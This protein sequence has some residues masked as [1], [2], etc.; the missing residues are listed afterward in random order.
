[1]RKKASG[2]L[3]FLLVLMIFL[4]SA[5]FLKIISFSPQGQL[6][7]IINPEIT[8]VFSKDMKNLGKKS[9]VENFVKISPSIEGKFFWRGSST[10]VFRAFK[11]FRYSTL[12]KVKIKKWIKSLKGNFLDRNYV[13][14]F[15]TPLARPVAVKQ[16]SL[17][18]DK[19]YG[20]EIKYFSNK[21]EYRVSKRIKVKEPL[22]IFF[23]QKINRRKNLEKIEIFNEKTLE[24][25]NVSLKFYSPDT[26]LIKFLSP[27]KEDNK[28]FIKLSKGFLS[29]E[30]PLPQ[31]RDIFVFFKTEKR[32]KY[33]GDKKIFIFKDKPIFNLS[34][35]KPIKKGSVCKARNYLKVFFIEDGVRKE[36]QD[37]SVSCYYN[38]LRIKLKN[39]GADSYLV[40]ISKD[41]KS[42]SGENLGENQFIR[43]KIC[44][45]TPDLF[46][47]GFSNNKL[48]LKIKG[49]L[50]LKF[51]ILKIKDSKL[52]AKK[53][54][55]EERGNVS[56]TRYAEFISNS[57]GD[58]EEF[59]IDFN[60][61][62]KSK[63]GIF[64]VKINR[65]KLSNDCNVL[66]FY[67]NRILGWKYIVNP[68]TLASSI[69]IL[70]GGTFI[71][72]FNRK[73]ITGES[74]VL[75]EFYKNSELSFK[76]KTDKDGVFYGDKRLD[77]SRWYFGNQGV[78]LLGKR[79][80]Y[81]F[82]YTGK[83]WVS[84]GGF[85]DETGVK[86]LI[87]TDRDFYLPGDSVYIGGI[88]KKRWKN[89]LAR[90]KDK[91]ITIII[92]DPTYK[93]IKRIE[94]KTDRFG[95]FFNEVKTWGGW[96][97]GKYFI[98]VK[99]KGAESREKIVKIDFYKLNKIELEE[100]FENEV[101][102]ASQ[103]NK[104][105]V[106][107]KYLSGAPLVGDKLIVNTRVLSSSYFFVNKLMKAYKK[108]CFYP[109]PVR[110][111]L[112][113]QE[114]RF[115][116]KGEAEILISLDKENIHSLSNIEVE[117]IGISKDGR[118]YSVRKSF[119]YIPSNSIVGIKSPYFIKRGKNFEIKLVALDKN[120]VE[121]S[122]NSRI[123]IKR[124]F[125]Q[126]GKYKSEKVY[127]KKLSFTG[128]TELKLSFNKAGYYKVKVV[129]KDNEGFSSVTEDSFYVWDY[130][131][132]FTGGI[133]NKLVFKKDKES[134][135]IGDIAKIYFSSSYEGKG[136]I[137][138]FTE[139]LED[140]Y[141][142]NFKKTT[143][144]SF[145][146]KKKY[147][148]SV[149]F[150]AFIH[151]YD[152]D[153]KRKTI[154][155]SGIIK[156]NDPEKSI[157]IKMYLKNKLQPSE[158]Q[159]LKLRTTNFKGNPLHSKIFVFAVDEGVLSLSGYKTPDPLSALYS[160]KMFS[161]LFYD[162]FSREDAFP[163]FYIYRGRRLFKST[164][165]PAVM[166]DKEGV[167]AVLSPVLKKDKKKA[168]LAGIKLRTLFKSTLFFKVVET[169]SKGNAIVKFKTSDLLTTYRL[170]VVAY[171]DDMFGSSD[172][173]FIVTKELLM[174]ES[175]PDFLRVGDKAVAGVMLTNRAGEK[176]SVNVFVKSD[177]KIKV[178]DQMKKTIHI[179]P[180][181]TQTV[182]FNT[183]ALKEGES[184]LKFYAVSGKFKDGLEKKVEII[185]NIVKESFVDFSSGKK[186]EKSFKLQKTKLSKLTLE[187]SS[188]V[189]N[190]SFS[191][192]KKIRIYPYECFEQRTSKLMP[193]LLIDKNLYNYCKLSYNRKEFS[194]EVKKYL[195]TLPH[196][197]SPAGGVGYYSNTHSSSYLTIYVLYALKLIEDKGF[198]IDKN[199]V[200]KMFDY[201]EYE[202]LSPEAL[203]F[204]SY[205]KTLWRRNSEKDIKKVLKEYENLSVLSRA[206]LLK[207]LS[208][209][210][211]KEKE[212]LKQQIIRD[213][214]KNIFVEADF[215]YFKGDKRYNYFEFPFYSNR[216]LT[217]VILGSI[218]ESGVNYPLS[219]RMVRYLLE[220]GVTRW[221][222]FTTHTNVWII[223][224]LN[225]YV[226]GIERGF[227]K[228]VNL[229]I[230][231][232]SKKILG[233]VLNFVHPQQK[234]VYSF[235]NKEGDLR[236][237]VKAK[238]DSLFYLTSW[239][240]E[241]ADL[242]KQVTNGI[243]VE[244]IIYNQKGEIVK[245]LKK[246]KIY[247][248]VLNVKTIE[249][250]NY[251][252]INEPLMGGVEVLRR[253]IKTTRKLFDF[254]KNKKRKFY[255]WWGVKRKEYKRD[256]LV[257]YTYRIDKE[258]E[259]SYYLKA[260]FSGT[261]QYLPP[262]AFSM[263]H[264]QFNGRGKRN[265]LRIEREIIKK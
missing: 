251:V 33:N 35:S 146:I 80:G 253:D 192:A 218:L 168:D 228:R 221:S 105:F 29:A 216:Y 213:F 134:Y 173:R 56:E 74:N 232:N 263:Y 252:V 255:W 159:V 59:S 207:A 115:D 87:F 185:E 81:S 16:N 21:I 92:K 13:F 41:F 26:I 89:H 154:A 5:D 250:M 158:K 178:I 223:Y 121:T 61:L 214:E 50:K 84:G 245:T 186:I 11:G 212:K 65:V 108:Y 243:F 200:N 259:I 175:F 42:I 75:F 106:S 36:T 182:Y 142:I 2:A 1:M 30:G 124:E 133:G 163:P 171:T 46:V 201:L 181:N 229:E 177:E 206:F 64:V 155:T 48:T 226:K 125:C 111:S 3:F 231:E 188:S 174:K 9:Q 219:S 14:S 32:F 265:E 190:S 82:A 254:R 256:R 161:Y 258:F 15:A 100:K 140:R 217:A 73:K 189:L 156:V 196:F 57:S 151:Y 224:A 184:S 132:S 55:L 117:A 91:K 170:I 40:K 107:G 194:K 260:L 103:K 127:D 60:T 101:I 83:S 242:S 114:F 17:Y 225:Q 211:V 39:L 119:F 130:N 193:Y 197:I 4:L 120:G 147:Y 54:G 162:T 38:Q 264:P 148:P 138:V 44:G 98:K 187:F 68:S 198:M 208:K 262:S 237:F 131:Y 93:V 110:K 51:T 18:K 63:D 220:K 160:I 195:K 144:F 49:V 123:V 10:L 204:Y 37:Y 20:S 85:F 129:S 248:V 126:D 238:S 6:K 109:H 203:A 99:V 145:K 94:T 104:V 172:K 149:S 67:K 166:M 164:G 95:G 235:E 210:E 141:L 118:E 43:V 97:R 135:N 150:L 25:V 71:K 53:M 116:S 183:I 246:G 179:E 215:A 90:F 66:G 230:I 52:F 79:G 157:N 72:S 191:I 102:T 88:V 233:K 62:F 113:R 70:E 199:L 176:L 77:L 112:K 241:K 128:K 153:D 22:Y 167:S 78:F 234:F 8:I 122:S 34:F 202:N 7:S 137:I 239:L 47:K 247:Q 165:R 45:Y 227:K 86:I 257:F 244:R 12:Y 209:S 222:W 169:D 27:L 249:P 24:K 58:Y 180:M 136:E 76:V 205:V 28:Y 143:E 236:L 23:N 261:F 152:K 139:E 240:R 69:L 96:K 31:K 19:F